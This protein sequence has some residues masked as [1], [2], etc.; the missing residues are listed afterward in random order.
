MPKVILKSGIALLLMGA[1]SAAALITP[2]A[3]MGQFFFMENEDVG[4][5]VKDF[6]LKVANGG[7]VNLKKYIEGKKAVIFFW[8][9]WC[10]HC[11]RE[12]QVLNKQR[13]DIV[14]KGITIVLVDVGESEAVV[15]QY[16][17]K[18]NIAMD[19]FL[20]EDSAVSEEY[21][22]IGVPTFYFVDENGI[23]AEVA[24]SLPKDLEA[25]F[26]KSESSAPDKSAPPL[27]A[28]SVVQDQGGVGAAD[29]GNQ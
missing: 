3:A 19:V 24:H 1:V 9:T 26:A 21:D 23:V 7:Q 20:D 15:D 8:A 25:V 27:E 2:M 14:Q 16:L 17:K 10:P 29:S 6:T 18:R 5:A 28:G 22:L 12:L 13:E 4:K 11:A